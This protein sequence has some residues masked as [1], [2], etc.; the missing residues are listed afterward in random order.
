MLKRINLMGKK[1]LERWIDDDKPIRFLDEEET[2]LEE[3]QGE[4]PT[5]K[6]FSIL[7]S[8]DKRL[9]FGW[10]SVS[11][12]IDGELLEDRQNDVI[13]PDDLETAAYEYVLA[14][15]DTGVE[16]IPSLRKK[17]RLVESC[18]FTEEKQ[19]AMGIPPGII[20]VGWWIGFRIDDDET[21]QQ[22]KE[23]KFKAFSIEGKATRVEMEESDEGGE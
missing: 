12:T 1:L 23:G 5:E 8:N 3:N 4:E 6:S 9:V 15:R 14:F 2:K 13:E 16:H 21:W 17:G 18:V 19:Q 10:A 7:K 11:M 20:P 22:V